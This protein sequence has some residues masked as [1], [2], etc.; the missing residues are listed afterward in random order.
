MTAVEQAAPAVPKSP[1]RDLRDVADPSR[2]TIHPTSKDAQDNQDYQGGSLL[3]ETLTWVT[4]AWGFQVGL[5]INFRKRRLEFKRLTRSNVDAQ[6]YKPALSRKILC[7]LCFLWLDSVFHQAAARADAAVPS[8][9]VSLGGP[10][11]AFV[12]HSFF[13]GFRTALPTGPP[14]TARW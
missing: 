5:R 13:V 12:D 9:L 6:D 7:P 1:G 11:C 2:R 10:S 4:L 14:P 8:R 3:H